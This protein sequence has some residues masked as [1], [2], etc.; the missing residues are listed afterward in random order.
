M[1]IIYVY[2]RFGDRG[3]RNILRAKIK[4]YLWITNLR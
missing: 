1:R 4:I 3:K 2:T